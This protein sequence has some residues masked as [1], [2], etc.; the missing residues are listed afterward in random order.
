VAGEHPE[1]RYVERSDGVSIAYQ[2]VGSGPID[3]VYVPG[4]I[5]HLDLA[6]SE[7]HFAGFLERLASFSRLVLFDKPG[8]GLSDPIAHVPTVEERRDDIGV[9]MDDAGCEAPVLLGFSEGVSSCLLFAATWPERVASLVLYG[10]IVKGRFSE[11]EADEFGVGEFI[12]SR[13]ARMDAAA[14]EWGRGRTA[15]L[16]FP[17]ID[18]PAER[19]FWA[20]FERAAAS[21]RM[22]RALLEAV[23]DVD[24]TATLPTVTA[25]TLL[26]HNVDDFAPIAGS[27]YMAKCMPNARLVELPGADHAF[28]MGDPEP[29]LGEIE[30]FVTGTRRV[31]DSGRVLATVLFTDVVDSTTRAAELGDARWR[32]LL[33][34]H[35]RLVRRSVEAH[36]GRVVKAMGDGYLSTFDGP[37]RGIRCALAIRDQS[38]LEIRAGLHTGECESIGEDLGGLAVHIGARVGSQAGPGEV[39]VSSTVK[40][41]VVGSPLSFQDRG[42]H[43]LKGVPGHWRLHVATGTEAVPAIA[44]ERAL[45]PSDRLTLRMA[46]RTPETM[47]TAAKVARRLSRPRG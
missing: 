13:W 23:R 44:P 4:F 10:G 21:P 1:T 29:V 27:R 19:R 12:E 41:L 26:L 34:D 28:W 33:A 20:L 35:D 18:S 9:V 37:A 32:E 43:E 15:E 2:V 7:P 5:S 11:E 39:L 47:R 3:L 8:T 38:D 40:D 24:V 17:S 30:H 16:L 22:A 31:P 25:P 42:E 46:R 6:W 14:A 36:G 45:R